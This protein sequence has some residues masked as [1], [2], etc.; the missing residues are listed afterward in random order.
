MGKRDLSL[1]LVWNIFLFRNGSQL[2]FGL[3]NG[4]SR[5][6]DAST[7]NGMG[8]M[9]HY[10]RDMFYANEKLPQPKVVAIYEVSLIGPIHNQCQLNSH[11]SPGWDHAT[12][13]TDSSS[14]LTTCLSDHVVN[15]QM[16]HW[17]SWCIRAPVNMVPIKRGYQWM[18]CSI[19]EPESYIS[20]IT[21]M[22]PL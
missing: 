13:K 7:D 19:S 15:P 18:A 14:G 1:K 16:T 22:N 9:T 20:T 3:Y 17:E 12:E 4:P 10:M 6:Y 2:S 21:A 11:S 5:A 8:W